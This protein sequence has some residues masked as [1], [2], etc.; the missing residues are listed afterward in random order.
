[1][2]IIA[3][4]YLSANAFDPTV[5]SSA[6][7]TYNSTADTDPIVPIVELVP[8]EIH[9]VRPTGNLWRRAHRQSKDSPQ[10]YE[11]VGSSASPMSAESDRNLNEVAHCDR[12]EKSPS[13]GA[14]SSDKF[15]HEQS[16]PENRRTFEKHPSRPFEATRIRSG[17]QSRTLG[18]QRASQPR[19][20]LRPSALPQDD[21][22]L[23]AERER[24]LD[25]KR[26][27][28]EQEQR[29]RNTFYEEKGMTR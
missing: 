16:I 19:K 2:G 18:K 1:M 15:C 5:S 7:Q 25:A 28:R 10:A 22:R 4:L 23:V 26:K 3:N 27:W 13:S 8:T 11:K 14:Q 12:N 17:D 6:A 29:C 9:A 24:L 20:S 21:P